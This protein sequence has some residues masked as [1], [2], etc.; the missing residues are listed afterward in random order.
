MASSKISTLHNT[1]VMVMIN[2]ENE[3]EIL[4]E[5]DSLIDPIVIVST[6][7]VCT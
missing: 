1:L 2:E 3:A 6:H 7:I 4:R 5:M